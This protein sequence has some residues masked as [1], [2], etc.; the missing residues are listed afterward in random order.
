MI[1]INKEK[2]DS[3]EHSSVKSS[4]LFA[5][6]LLFAGET[7]YPSGGWEDF[8]EAFDT[9][10]AAEARGQKQIEGE[11]DWWNIINLKTGEMTIS[12]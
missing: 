2:D 11:D 8:I 3:Q 6:F 5:G 4:G 10:E 7:Y 12:T 1:D 9:L